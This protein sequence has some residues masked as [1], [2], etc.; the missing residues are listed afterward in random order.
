MGFHQAKNCLT[1]FLAVLPVL[2]RAL[3]PPGCFGSDGNYYNPGDPMTSTNPCEVDC[4]CKGPGEIECNKIGCEIPACE[5]PITV[6]GSCCPVCQC[7]QDGVIYNPGDAMYSDNPCEASCF[8]GNDGQRVCAVMSCIPCENPIHIDG[9]CCPR[10]I[11]NESGQIYN[12]GDAM[13]SDNPCEASCF[14]GND[15]QRVCA[16]MACLPCENPIHVDGECCPRCVCKQDEQIYN[17][18][19]II[20]HDPCHPCQCQLDGTITCETIEC[21]N[22]TCRYRVHPKESCCP[23]CQCMRKY[24]RYLPGQIVVNST[25]KPQVC[26]PDGS[27]KVEPVTCPDL[28]LQCADPVVPQG[29]CCPECPNG[30]T[31]AYGKYII[32][33]GE[34]KVIG[35]KL[36]RC[37]GNPWFPNAFCTETKVSAM[38]LR[39]YGKYLAAYNP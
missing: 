17:V 10:C 12:I 34:E 23:I 35:T 7:E 19:E 21:P 18:G 28:Q 26:Q 32:R 9:E 4:I 15:G 22:I 25:C 13:H 39:Y 33:Y 29:K 2:C 6:E 5:N 16:M 14:C 1:V 11:C 36:C 24:K 30:N 20:D 27:I 3:T 38:L 37:W 31:C 8:C